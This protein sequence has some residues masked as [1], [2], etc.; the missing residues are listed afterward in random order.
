[1]KRLEEIKK[2]LVAHKD[3][4]RSKYGVETIGVFGSYIRGDQEDSSDID[5]LVEFER[6]VGLLEFVRLKNYL[7]DLCEVNVDLVMKK[8]LRPRIGVRILKEVVY[9]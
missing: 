3:E 5:I 7:S 1:M 2:I 4:L 9:V 6:P 8:A